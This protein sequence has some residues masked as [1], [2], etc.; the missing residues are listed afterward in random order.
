M[1]V[2]FNW[3]NFLCAFKNLTVF[4]IEVLVGPLV[5]IV[6]LGV[7]LRLQILGWSDCDCKLTSAD[8]LLNILI[9][10]LD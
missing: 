6:R 8:N 3:C 9:F 5:L 4:K 2:D 1:A 7:S 10:Q